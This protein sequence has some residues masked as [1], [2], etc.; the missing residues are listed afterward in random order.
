MVAIEASEAEVLADSPRLDIA[1]INGPHSVVVSGDE[2]EAV[3]Y[4]EQWRARGRRVKRLSV[5]HAFHSA[6]MEPMLADFKHTLAGA[7]FTEP[8]LTLISNVT[9]RPA[10]PTE[11]CTPDYWVTHVRSTVRFADGI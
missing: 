2:P 1:A 7:T 8:T 5:G 9:G 6:R 4:A 10:P 3:A 11:I